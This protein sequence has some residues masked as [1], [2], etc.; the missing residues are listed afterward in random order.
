M[1]NQSKLQAYPYSLRTVAMKDTQICGYRFM[2]YMLP[3]KGALTIERLYTHFV[4]QFASGVAVADRYIQ[5]I[6]I[7]DEIPLLIGTDANYQRRETLNV[8]ADSNRRI[9][10]SMD[11]THLLNKDN[12][13]YEEG[14]FDPAADEGFTFVE[15][16][17]SPNL[18]ESNANYLNVGDIELWKIDG[19]FTT[20][21]IR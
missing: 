21:G 18:N 7:V 14:G 6:G 16:V 17:L 2:L 13:A 4:L 3:P 1:G 20:T 15:V 11:L 9:D 12:V 10:I 8:Q 5:S 19:L